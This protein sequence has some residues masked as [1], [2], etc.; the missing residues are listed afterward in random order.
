VSNQQHA[1]AIALWQA[2]CR[3]A[4]QEA[5]FALVVVVALEHFLSELRGE[6]ERLREPDPEERRAVRRY[7]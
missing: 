4:D 2:I 5:P 6:R 7:A 1:E 3:E